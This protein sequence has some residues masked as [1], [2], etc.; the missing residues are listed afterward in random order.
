[1]AFKLSTPATNHSVQQPSSR[2]VQGGRTTK[3]SN[4]TGW[5]ERRII[6]SREDDITITVRPSEENNPDLLAYNIY[7]K[8]NL[9]WLVLQYNNIVDPVVELRAGVRLTLPSFERVMLS[10]MTRQPGG[11][12][13]RNN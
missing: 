9:G 7:E 2:Y 4:R 6:P 5:W 1:M 13:L 8:A 12:R 3:L 11:H 10:I